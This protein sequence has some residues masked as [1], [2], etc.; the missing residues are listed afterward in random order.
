MDVLHLKLGLGRKAHGGR[1][2]AMRNVF[3]ADGGLQVVICLSARGRGFENVGLSGE[4]VVEAALRVFLDGLRILEAHLSGLALTLGVEQAIVGRRHVE[5]ELAMGVVEGQ[6]GDEEIGFGHI[7]GSTAPAPV[8]DQIVDVQR[9][10][11]EAFR[12]A[13][14]VFRDQARFPHRCGHG[15]GGKRG[16]EGGFGD[17]D[18]LGAGFGFLPGNAR[19]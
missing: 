14:E 12:L 17:A 5:D 9:R 13:T 10:N 15:Y 4:A 3:G 18:R 1:Q 6:V 2:I 16:V 7:D 19:L 8:E 11:E